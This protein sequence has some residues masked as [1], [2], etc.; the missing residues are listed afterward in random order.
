MSTETSSIWR[1]LGWMIV[2]WAASVASLA[3]VAFLLRLILKTD[4]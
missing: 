3:V 4:S 2:I 1:R